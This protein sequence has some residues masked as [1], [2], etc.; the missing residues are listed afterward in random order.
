MNLR[1]LRY[2]KIRGFFS[3]QQWTLDKIE[4]SDRSK[5]DRILVPLQVNGGKAFRGGCI[6][7]VVQEDKGG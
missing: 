4:Y 3:S 7:I 5:N 1:E 6:Y 2:T